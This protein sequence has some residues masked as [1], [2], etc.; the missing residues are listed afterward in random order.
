MLWV[1]CQLDKSLL[2]SLYQLMALKRLTRVKCIPQTTI[3][4]LQH[5]GVYTY[6][7]KYTKLWKQTY[8]YTLTCQDF[9][10]S[11]P[12][13]LMAVLGFSYSQLQELI[14][15]ISKAVA[16]NSK[17]V[18]PIKKHVYIRP[19]YLSAVTHNH[20]AT[21]NWY[22]CSFAYVHTYVGTSTVWAWEEWDSIHVTA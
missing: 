12:L 4:A 20:V 7:V 21:C 8:S 10:C 15:T 1:D 16:P 14:T 2:S 6:K 3:E 5:H 22:P 9:L 13:E 11:S 17:N 19:L 18:Y